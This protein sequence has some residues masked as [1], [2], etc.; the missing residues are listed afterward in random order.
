MKNIFSTND[1]HIVTEANINYYAKPFIH[2]KRKMKEHD[3]IYLL[4][5]EWKLGQNSENYTL[6]EDCLLILA[7]NN[8]HYGIHPCSEGTKTMY[9]HVSEAYGDYQ[10]EKNPEQLT[11][12]I[13]CETL[14]NCSENKKIK[15]I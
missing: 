12:G 10:T 14:I 5:G 8:L 4:K 9:F 2:P 3:F 6:N 11:D 15:K 13:A 1:M 7:A